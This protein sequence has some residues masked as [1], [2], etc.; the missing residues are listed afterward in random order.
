MP[1]GF[2]VCDSCGKK[3][4]PRT[5][6]CECGRAFSI[7]TKSPIAI[8]KPKEEIN[9]IVPSDSYN[10]FI[11]Y[12]IETPAGPCPVKFSSCKDLNDWV[13]QIQSKAG[14]STYSTR[15]L[16]YWLR[17]QVDE[18]TYQGLKNQL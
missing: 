15:A 3:C 6:V 14:E 5:A 7:K 4:G 18:E 10:P 16:L 11:G 12:V 17:T 9:E 8:E 1:R 13:S 2:K